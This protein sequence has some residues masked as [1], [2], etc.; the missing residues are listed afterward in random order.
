MLIISLLL[1]CT[2][3]ISFHYRVENTHLIKEWEEY[4]SEYNLDFT[5]KENE[6]RK[7]IFMKNY[8]FIMNS[9]SRNLNLNL[10]M[11]KF[12]HLV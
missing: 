5:A 10:K 12:G 7:E 1:I 8:Q 3:K 9:N 4:K 6:Y 11:N 2:F